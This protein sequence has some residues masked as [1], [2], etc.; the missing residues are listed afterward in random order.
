MDVQDQNESQENEV[1]HSLGVLC[2]DCLGDHLPNSEH[3][4]GL[5][6]S[7]EVKDHLNG[8]I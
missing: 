7:K 5:K 8:G 1:K 3:S 4:H 2:E 6:D